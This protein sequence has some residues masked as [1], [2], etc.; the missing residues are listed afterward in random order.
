M[1]HPSLPMVL[2][3]QPPPRRRDSL[4]RLD[5]AAD[6]AVVPD[7]PP[8]TLSGLVV[9]YGVE[10]NRFGGPIVFA[11]GCLTLPDQLSDVKLLIQHDDDR[12]AGY[13]VAAEETDTGL[14]MS[15]R[16]ADHPRAADLAAE[17]D[18]LLRDGLS[19]G[20]EPDDATLD[21]VTARFWG[22]TD[23]TDPIV[24]TG[25]LR[26]VS[27][28][29]VPQFNSA[30]ADAATAAAG[31]VTFTTGRTAPM[32]VATLPDPPAPT[33]DVTVTAGRVVDPPP[34]LSLAELAAAVSDLLGPAPAP[35]HPLARFAS[36]SEYAAAAREDPRLVFVLADQVT[37]DNPGLI[38][39][40]WLTQIVGLIA[41][42]S[43][44]STA[45]AGS[46]PPDGMSV[47]WPTYTGDYKTLV[48]KQAAE[49]TG[50]H[51]EKVSITQGGPALVETYAGGSDVSYQVIKR[52]N[53]AY[54]QVY[55]QIL[56]KAYAWKNE[57]VCSTALNTSATG[58]GT[59]SLTASASEVKAALFAASSDVQIATGRPAT[60][61][62]AAPDRFAYLGAL[63]GLENPSYGTQNVAGTSS[64]ATL[65]V[66]INGLEV[67]CAPAFQTGKLTV[68]NT[69]AAAWL[70]DGP[71]TVTAEDVEKLGQNVA[72][73]GLGAFA[74][75]IPDGIVALAPTA[76]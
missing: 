71:Y 53:P 73:W 52:A 13:A 42:A 43:P 46:L 48:D 24:F 66:N 19:V 67:I 56:A 70:R 57:A 64:A 20:V 50:I 25:A 14:R 76:P 21:A 59:L 16:L 60:H 39:P 9:P 58:S 23:S 35:V 2:P 28:V 32:P 4:Y 5:L 31:V 22:E 27:A 47:V 45:L 41:A 34:Q 7:A 72:I 26:E 36:F 37:T 12:P 38:Q 62:F 65:R 74:P 68:T 17:V 6:L 61:V 10:T 1:T 49:K 33:P 3:T 8:G 18:Q 44:V 54:L 55:N 40:A 29:S 69:D 11:R 51:S 15:F 75:F 63:D 30:R